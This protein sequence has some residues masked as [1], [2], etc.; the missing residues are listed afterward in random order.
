MPPFVPYKT[1]RPLAG[2][3]CNPS[4]LGRLGATPG[5]TVI[6]PI[7]AQILGLRKKGFSP[8]AAHDA[9][10][11][12]LALRGV[13]TITPDIQAQLVAGL[14]K[15]PGL[16][17]LGSL[18]AGVASAGFKAGATAASVAPVAAAGLG[19]GSAIV[20]GQTAIPIPVVGAVIGAVIGAALLLTRRHVGAAE[21]SW[22]A[23]GFYASLNNTQGRDYDEKQ[24]SEAFKGMMDTGNNIV[25]GCGADR[26]K[27]PDCL[28]GPMAAVIANGYLTGAVPLSA[29][30]DQAF[31]A[32]VLPWLQS[33]AGGLVNWGT[34]SGEP[35]QLK[36][37]KAATDRYLAGEAMTRGDMPSYGNK[38]KNTPTLIQVLQPILQ[39]AQSTAPPSIPLV[40]VP[41]AQSVAPI[42]L[43]ATVASGANTPINNQAQLADSTPLTI[44]GQTKTG[45]AIVP[46]DQTAAL[47]A[48]MQTQGA[49]QQQAFAAAIASLQAQGV[50]TSQPAVQQQV[51]ADVSQMPVG[52]SLPVTAAGFG[53]GLPTWLT[54]GIAIVG[55]GFVFVRPHT[56]TRSKRRGR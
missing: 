55:L 2:L 3:G 48:Q 22:T 56:P 39:P 53:T 4:P 37:M 25:P 50:N 5:T 54:I 13:T 26:H 31:N 42:P 30:L 18:G 17:G 34:L 51:A 6:G 1:N 9:A 41:T 32:S 14:Q 49:S 15:T 52:G 36:M 19:M 8:K 24:F 38:G 7:A 23:P 44:T 11:A 35:T 45:T 12:T 29:T 33:G 47:I 40:P 10:L 21:A 27:D 20:L 46:I 28:L 43:P 16:S